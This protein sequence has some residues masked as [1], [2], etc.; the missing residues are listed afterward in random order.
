MSY[1]VTAIQR[2]HNYAK[3]FYLKSANV[4]SP[5]VISS[6]LHIPSL[7]HLFKSGNSQ[8]G[9]NTENIEDQGA[10][11]SQITFILTL[12]VA[13]E[14]FSFLKV[15]ADRCYIQ[16]SNIII[17]KVIENYDIHSYK[18]LITNLRKQHLTFTLTA[19]KFNS[20]LRFLFSWISNLSR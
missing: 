10:I 13:T 1:L 18:V 5:K 9:L 17:S 14:F 11:L 15:I 6:E 4:F 12:S 16:F 7:S 8:R 3:T 20:A 2:R 19:R